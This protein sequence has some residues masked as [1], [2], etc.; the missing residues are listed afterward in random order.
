MT[1]MTSSL[2][3]SKIGNMKQYALPKDWNWETES[4][5]AIEPGEYILTFENILREGEDDIDGEEMLRRAVADG[6]DGSLQHALWL[7]ENQYR[8]PKE[9][10]GERYLVFPKAVALDSRQSRRVLCLYWDGLRWGLYWSWLTRN[11]FDRSDL[12]VRARKSPPKA[13]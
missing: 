6:I 2:T 11:F 1:P 12:V 9:F 5:L 13:A 3:P 7:L 4:I 8:I 10:R